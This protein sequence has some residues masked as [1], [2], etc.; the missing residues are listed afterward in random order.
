MESKVLVKVGY[1]FYVQSYEIEDGDITI[2]LTNKIEK[3]DL[4]IRPLAEQIAH[5][6]HGFCLEQVSH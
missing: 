4:I 2:E 1:G 3:A 5:A 6:V